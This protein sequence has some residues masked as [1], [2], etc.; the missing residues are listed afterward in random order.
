MSSKHLEKVQMQMHN[1]ASI[2]LCCAIIAEY[3]YFI[4]IILQ[5]KHSWNYGPWGDELN[6][7]PLKPKLLC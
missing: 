1:V 3:W 4:L 7:V 5:K 6:A 2:S